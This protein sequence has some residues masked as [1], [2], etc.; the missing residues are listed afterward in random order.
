MSIIRQPLPYARRPRF[1]GLGG[2]GDDFT[3]DPGSIAQGWS[4]PVGSGSATIDSNPWIYESAGGINWEM[5]I[6]NIL[7]LA[8]NIISSARG[9][10]YG[11]SQY[12]QQGGQQGLNLTGTS[13]LGGGSL[14][15]SSSTLMLLGLGLVVIFMMKK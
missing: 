7:K 6:P 9:G 1:T 12:G 15:I 11:S 8:P 5:F 10:S 13:L 14:G 2:L 3:V 4:Q